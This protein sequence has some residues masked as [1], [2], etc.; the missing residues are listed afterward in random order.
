MKE[1]TRE[2]FLEAQVKDLNEH[3]RKALNRIAELEK[4]NF[5]LAAGQCV[6]EG[7]IDVVEGVDAPFCT[8]ELQLIKANKRIAVLEQKLHEYEM[9]VLDRK[10]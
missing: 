2:E 8:I 4:E 5:A 9:S 1:G 6:V 3:L 7:S 10:D